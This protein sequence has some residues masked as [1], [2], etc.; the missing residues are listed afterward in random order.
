MA[1]EAIQEKIL[2]DAEKEAKRI[3][4]EALREAEAILK[5][6]EAEADTIKAKGMEEIKREVEEHKN[7]FLAMNSLESRKEL[8]REKQRLIEEV[9]N[10][11]IS[12][13]MDMKK[14]DFQGLIKGILLRAIEKGDEE[15]I[16]APSTRSLL[17]DNF[18]VEVNAELKRKGNKGE[19]TFSS[20]NSKPPSGFILKSGRM[21]RNCSIEAIIAALKDDL[22]PD[23][24]GVL[25]E[26]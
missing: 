3:K 24:A 21:E 4:E 11:S 2:Q 18:L 26:E 22:E 14:E 12:M 23:I 8:L 17:N 9:F 6:A 13:I 10:S 16:F 7:R 19:L 25:F 1:I 20:Q 15:V 5:K